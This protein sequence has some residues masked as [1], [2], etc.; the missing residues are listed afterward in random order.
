MTTRGPQHVSLIEGGTALRFDTEYKAG[1]LSQ[2]VVTRQPDRP[3]I[4]KLEIERSEASGWKDQVV[5]E[6]SLPRSSP[7]QIAYKIEVFGHRAA[8]G[9]PLKVVEDFAPHISVKRLD[10]AGSPRS[11]RLTVTDIF[12]QQTSI[13]IPVRPTAPAAAGAAAGLR[14]GLRYAYYEAPEGARW[15]RLPELT[16]FA[17]VKRGGVNALDVSVQRGGK[18]PYAVRFAGFLRVP[19][20]GLYSFSL[21]SLDGSRL[22]LGGK[23]IGDNDGL[24]T[25][26]EK[27]YPAAL[28]K[29][30]H[31]FEVLHFR[32]GSELSIEQLAV[33]WEG[34]G[35]ERRTL[36]AGDLFREVSADVPSI[37]LPPAWGADGPDDNLIEIRPKIDRRGRAVKKVEYYCG[38]LLLN[39]VPE[40]PFLFRK[41]LPQGRNRMMARL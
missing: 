29:G 1:K 23:V 14:P 20:G 40:E 32:G 13:V 28:A 31:S 10:S 9:R 6:W 7:P 4:D 19:A 8:G 16:G 38:K 25:R 12:D 18:R 24:H 39:T 3:V 37:T 33:L 22:R 30:L 27:Q 36:G 15:E 35:I 41:V 11:V 17:P 21:K 2:P 5:V 34:P 26:A